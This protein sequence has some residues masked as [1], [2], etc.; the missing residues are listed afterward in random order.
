MNVYRR[1]VGLTGGVASGKSTVAAQF[2]AR[3]VCVVDVDDISRTLTAPGGIALHRIRREFPSAFKEDVLD[4][5]LLREIVFADLNRRRQ[6]ES[7]LHPMIRDET[8]RSLASD[9]ARAATY[10]MLVVPL[11]FEGSTYQSAIDCAV[12]VDIPRTMQIERMV[13]TRGLTA[14]MA[15][16]IINAQYARETRI[17]RTQF[18]IDN[19]TS[20]EATAAQIERLH[21]VF[22]ATYLKH[23]GVATKAAAIPEAT[24]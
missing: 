2:A 9:S 22:V 16:Q 20:R 1:V 14:A 6:L 5:A 13:A 19:S 10:I 15:E 7:I 17:E 18:V 12:T 24:V 3:G 11:L 4:R 21:S 23:S 8:E